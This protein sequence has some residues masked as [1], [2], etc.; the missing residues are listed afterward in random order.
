MLEDI[1]HFF[2]RKILALKLKKAGAREIKISTLIGERSN[3]SGLFKLSFF[4]KIDFFDCHDKKR[5][6]FLRPYQNVSNTFDYKDNSIY[7]ETDKDKSINQLFYYQRKEDSTKILDLIGIK[8]KYTIRYQTTEKLWTHDR[9]IHFSKFLSISL[10]TKEV[11][12]IHFS[13]FKQEILRAYNIIVE[14]YSDK[15]IFILNEC[16]LDEKGSIV[17]KKEY[18]LKDDIFYL[19]RGLIELLKKEPEIRD[20]IFR[21]E[22][23][24]AINMLPDNIDEHSLKDFHALVDMLLV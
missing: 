19:E 8:K 3:E 5:S 10:K 20:Q 24:E 23:I 4:S 18:V 17:L 7:I 1:H 6:Y 12:V 2:L 9:Y 22:L 14:Q 11:L 16:G 15:I 21:K 13:A